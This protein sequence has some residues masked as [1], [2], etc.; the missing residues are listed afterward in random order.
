[1]I[2]ICIRESGIRMAGHAGR[3]ESDGIDRVCAA[4]SALTCAL[5]NGLTD[6]TGDRI[7]AYT[8]SGTA[9]V[10]WEN[11]TD[12]APTG[13]EGGGTAPSPKLRKS[14]LPWARSSTNSRQRCR[15]TMTLLQN[16]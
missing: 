1:M 8:D 12:G 13:S 2:Q 16:R 4:V 11:L 6:L 10:E 15:Q 5:I 9:I 3:T 7:R 14:V